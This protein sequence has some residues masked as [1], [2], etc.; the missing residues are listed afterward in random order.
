MNTLHD[1]HYPLSFFCEGAGGDGQEGSRR[2]S[3]KKDQGVW[4]K[5]GQDTDQAHER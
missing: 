1:Y 3:S 4:D 2:A 5:V